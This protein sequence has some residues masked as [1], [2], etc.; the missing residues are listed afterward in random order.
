MAASALSA[1]TL[2]A[3]QN[4]MTLSSSASAEVTM[5]LL[6]VTLA[7]SREGSDAASV[8]GQLKQAL[9]TALS[10]ARRVA[11][12]G[13]LDV[14]TGNFSLYP[15]YAPKGGITGWQGRAELVVE[16]RDTQAIAQLTGRIQS[17]SIARV[18]YGLSREVRERTEAEVTAQAIARFRER[19]LL[20]SQQFG[21]SGYT[22]REVQVG[23]QDPQVY[24]AA[25]QMRMKSSAAAMDEALP[26]E[27]G[28]TTVTSSVNGTV[29]M[30]R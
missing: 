3:P 28:K 13:Q 10:E 14:Q 20:H 18:G 27:A 8:Q 30:T 19:A 21:F 25:P 11:K 29:Q 16:G 26:V 15:R 17:L 7:T 23:T 24:A 5:D 9:D 4:V 22:V 1:Q 2:P 12:P 6:Q